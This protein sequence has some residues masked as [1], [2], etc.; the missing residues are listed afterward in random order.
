MTAQL[1]RRALRIL[2]LLLLALVAVA[3]GD[4]KK[5][6]AA[7]GCDAGS[8]ECGC[9]VDGGC[10]SGLTCEDGQCVP[11]AQACTD[12]SIGCVCES[13][14]DCKGTL[15][16][17]EGACQPEGC[18][19]G[20]LGCACARGDV[21]GRDSTG[22]TLVCS[23]GVCES[24]ACAAGETGCA[25][26]AGECD[27]E[28]DVCRNGF[29]QD[30]SCV[31]GESNCE[32]LGG[33]CNAGLFCRDG[34][35]CV[36]NA[37]FEGGVCLD[38]NRC[39]RNNR[40]DATQNI[41]IHC[42]LGSQ[43]CQCTDAGACNEGLHCLADLCVP[44]NEVPPSEA[45]CYTPCR[46]D[47]VRADETITCDP[48]GALLGCVD[49]KECV[50]G[51]CVDPGESK[52]TCESD[53]ECTAFQTCIQGGCY[54]NCEVHADCPSGLGCYKKVCRTPCRTTSSGD[55]CP[56]G[57]HCE[58]PDGEN[59][60]CVEMPASSSLAPGDKQAPRATVTATETHLDFSNIKTK[61]KFRVSVAQGPETVTVRKLS[62]TLY[63]ADGTV[64]RAKAP[65]DRSV[66]CDPSAEDCPLSWI[67]ITTDTETSKDPEIEIS[68]P[69]SC[70]D[71]DCPAIEIG[72]TGDTTVPRWEGTVELV[73]PSGREVINLSYAERADGQWKGS[74]YYLGTFN[75]EGLE[76][77]L[78]RS[79][80]S[81]VQ[82]VNNGLIQRWGAFRKG[83]LQG[84]WTELEAVLT[85]TRTGSWQFSGVRDLCRQV[86]SGSDIAA[87]YPFT[88]AAGAR[89]YVQD[90]RSAPIPSGTTEFPIALNLRRGS[91]ATVLEGRIDT[92]VALHYPGNPAVTLEL[93]AAPDDASSCSSVI[94]DECVVFLKDMNAS[95][96]VGGRYHPAGPSCADGFAMQTFPWLLPDFAGGSVAD[97]ATG[98]RLRQECRDRLT[99]SNDDEILNASLA[100]ANPVPDGARRLRTVELLDGALVGQRRLFIMFREQFESFV[101]DE[102]AAYGYMVLERSP[103]DLEDSDFEGEAHDSS[104]T[105]ASPTVLGCSLDSTLPPADAEKIAT[106][107]EGTELA[108]QSPLP[109]TEIHYLCEDTGLFDGGPGDDG[110]LAATQVECP[111]GSKVTFFW[112]GTNLSQADIAAEACQDAGSCKARLDQWLASGA[113]VEEVDPLYK[114]AN[115]SDA[116]CDDNRLDLRDEKEFYAAPVAQPDIYVPIQPAIAEAFRYKTRFQ[117]GDNSEVGFAPQVCVPGSDEIPYC[118][119][120]PAI[121]ELR[122]RVDCL[123]SIYADDSRYAALDTTSQGDLNAFL[124]ENF[125]ELAGRDGFERL[126]AELLVLLGDEALTKAFSSRFD[127]AG[128]GGA[129][130]QGSLFEAE[131]IDLSGVAGFEMRN[132]YQATQYYQTAID[133]FYAFGE[134]LR[135]ALSRGNVGAQ[136]NFVTAEMV[137]LYVERLIRA[138]TQKARAWGEV[139]ERYQGFNRPDLARQVLERAYTQAYL[140]GALIGRFMLR[141]AENAQASKQD[142]IRKVIENAQLRYRVALLRMRDAFDAISDETTIFGFPADYV[143][144]PAVDSLEA[145]ANGFDVL[146]GIARSKL[147]LAKQRETSAL[148]QNRAVRTDAASFQGELVRVRNT[149]E[150]ELGDICGTFQTDDG[151]VFPAIRKYA[152]LD[153]LTR[154]LGDP[155]GR[156]GNGQLA[157]ALL[158]L[159]RAGVELGQ[160]VDAV[161]GKLET[162]ER[163]EQRVKK[164]CDRITSLADFTFQTAGK[165]SDSQQEAAR[166]R[167]EAERAQRAAD[168]AIQVAGALQCGSAL[169]CATGVV[170]GATIGV[171]SAVAGAL[172]AKQED[173]ALKAEASAAD[174]EADLQKRQIT[175]ECEAARIDSEFNV[176]TMTLELLQA[177]H[178]LHQTAIDLQIA[179]GEVQR[180][181]N[182]AER[183]QSQQEEAE[184]LLINVEA[185]RNDPNVRIYRNEAVINADIAFEDAIRAMYRATLVFEYYTSQSYAKRDELFLT[186]MA[187]LGQYNLENYINELEN[188]FFTFE[189]QFGLPDVRVQVLSLRDDIL[190]VPLLADDGAPLSQG[191]RIDLMRE[192][193]QDVSLLDRRGYI[194]I[195][196]GTELSAL[197]PLTRNHKI[198]SVEVDVVGSDVGDTVGRVYLT[199]AGSGLVHNVSGGRDYYVFP[200]KT[201]VVDTIFNG[202]RVFP[203]EVYRNVRLRDR[204]LVNTQYQLVINRKDEEAN[205]DIDLGSLSDVRLFIYYTDFTAL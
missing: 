201:A 55:A 117:S 113:V 97:A 160:A 183:W 107:I 193:L 114:C 111:F 81:D 99:P 98:Q 22:D 60:Y 103:Q 139:A 11:S 162:I 184:Q 95:V 25:C 49:G 141:I 108:A 8:E 64:E 43:G 51:S 190:D 110:S 200:E 195:P 48:D 75:E 179:V 128:V 185:A 132:L 171:A 196:F 176:F 1:M 47:L 135:V 94:D 123:L 120:P 102:S 93:D 66:T 23:D 150:N 12:G 159:E 127:L 96:V 79:D 131:G 182:A 65:I 155:C 29:C 4:D 14:D 198:Q 10:G 54:S 106:L 21:C 89:V 109:N 35:I 197:S 36:D 140:E 61:R 38:N 45:K 112:V 50:E 144:F 166:A 126:Y 69:A 153:D 177:K 42:E 70:S 152:H 146:A 56:G 100:G 154:I 37:G 59:G 129:A 76:A 71:D 130:F 34:S 180:L 165:I 74:A 92:S 6:H 151:R 83:N 136:A 86:T 40:C 68:V 118:Y 44:A 104:A 80:K 101:G 16:C 174:L 62:H 39:H 142:Q 181:A 105:D 26:A 157:A 161:N 167:V 19:T 20:A 57:E 88:N 158:Q 30:E 73:S 90:V 189:E 119:D 18:T 202:N 169:E 87:C 191:E 203:P 186:R 149:Y 115:P 82:G 52:P 147:D 125:S 124:Q 116:Y 137:T 178:E 67:E 204:P 58:A 143:P 17:I 72:K 32:C 85:S 133:R 163:E 13:I 205:R 134:A 9:L 41:C 168:A 84:G 175:T 15:D 192:R 31:P 172:M 187:A 27:A 138:S 2:S 122:D 156:M 148:E 121:E 24:A 78:A 164:Q 3:C 33:G 91:D 7:L 188:A 194:V 28:G 46:R 53:L 199:Q 77:W 173:N 170:A 145:G 63:H 5:K